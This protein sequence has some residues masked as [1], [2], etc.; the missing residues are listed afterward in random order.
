MPTTSATIVKTVLPTPDFYGD[1]AAANAG[2]DSVV[3]DGNYA[4]MLTVKIQ[5]PVMLRVTSNDFEN[6]ASCSVYVYFDTDSGVSADEAEALWLSGLLKK[7]EPSVPDRAAI[8]VL[9]LKFTANTALTRTF[10]GGTKTH[11]D[12]APISSAHKT[13]QAVP[14]EMYNLWK[15]T[16]KEM[17]TNATTGGVSGTSFSYDSSNPRTQVWPR[18]LFTKF[19][20]KLYNNI[21]GMPTSGMVV[22][23]TLMAELIE[24]E[25]DYTTA[26]TNPANGTATNYVAWSTIDRE[27]DTKIHTTSV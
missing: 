19:T 23:S 14:F 10:N 3:W 1:T 9:E 16:A 26:T 6:P 5:N 18:L 22:G 2:T 20:F 8:R 15:M 17:M 7:I 21:A 12:G 4:S 27:Y 25:A 13:T 11:I 24:A